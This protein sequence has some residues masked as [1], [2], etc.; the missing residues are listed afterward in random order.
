MKGFLKFLFAI[1][2]PAL[3]TWYASTYNIP[4]VT[5]SVLAITL[6]LVI[7]IFR[8]NILMVAGINIYRQNPEKGIKIMRSAYKTRRLSP[9][10]QLIFA[11]LVLRNGELDEAEAVMTKATVM[12]K[13]A[14][15]P[16]EFQA[17]K[18]NK[19]LITWKRGDLSQAIV[20]LEELYSEGY[21]TA[22][23]YGSLGSF[24]ILNKEYGKA[25]ELSQE[26]IKKLPSD[27]VILDNIG[28]AY[29]GLG[30]L[31]DA[32][33]VYETLIPR[34]PGFLEAYYN[35]GIVLEKR[36]RLTKA[37]HNLE[38]ALTLDEKFLS[39]VT[40]DEVC[41]AL[42]RINSLS[43]ENVKIED[44]VYEGTTDPVEYDSSKELSSIDEVLTDV[45]VSATEE[46][47][48]EET[49]VQEDN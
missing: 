9:S 16:E 28:Q 40:H 22:G 39:T 10:H 15:S 17:V 26:G 45:S 32:F 4:A 47:A 24:Y 35:Y 23:L 34:K 30:M 38:T 27:L 44:I 25:L 8:S 13:H 42:E 36:D 21:A 6:L 20:Q 31:D 19:A 37:K 5:W 1:L 33:K 11:Y 29:I 49:S 14:L 46:T 2:L 3:C 7:F 41:E 12:G 48:S 18:L 43:I